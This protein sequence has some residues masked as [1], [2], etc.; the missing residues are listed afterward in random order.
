MAYDNARRVERAF[1]TQAIEEESMKA[2]GFSRDP[3]TFAEALAS[4]ERAQ[5][6]EGMKK[7]LQ[8]H[9]RNQIDVEI[10]QKTPRSDSDRLKIRFQDQARPSR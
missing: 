10:F 7:E 1:L 4:P 8:N 2:N 5:W 6:I 9:R 3:S